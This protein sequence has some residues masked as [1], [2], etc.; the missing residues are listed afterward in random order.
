MFEKYL[1]VFCRNHFLLFQFQV[2]GMVCEG[3]ISYRRPR[4]TTY[5][6]QQNPTTPTVFIVTI[7][8][9]RYFGIFY[10]HILLCLDVEISEEE[11]IQ[12]HLNKYMYNF[13]L[14]EFFSGVLVPF[15]FDSCFA[16]NMPSG[17]CESFYSSLKLN[18]GSGEQEV[19][20]NAAPTFFLVHAH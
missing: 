4:A 13:I 8:I 17:N 19:H 5:H 14:N 11:A 2:V 7:R 15:E 3:Q 6:C 9:D 12:N 20:G 16:F 10:F 1:L 18:S